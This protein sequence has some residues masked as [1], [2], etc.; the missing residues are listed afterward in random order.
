MSANMFSLSNSW[1]RASRHIRSLS[2]EEALMKPSVSRRYFVVG[3]AALSTLPLLRRISAATLSGPMIG[4]EVAIE[5]FS[6]AGKSLGVA[7]VPKIA[8]TD[9]QWQAQLS[10]IAY[11]VARQAGTEVAFT[12]EWY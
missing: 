10:P 1:I 2:A 3:L 7:R 9:A 6:P 5:N 12:G 4:G 8:K 11:R